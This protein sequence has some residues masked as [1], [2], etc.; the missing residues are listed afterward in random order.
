MYRFDANGQLMMLELE[1]A[2][3]TGAPPKRRPGKPD[4]ELVSIPYFHLDLVSGSVDLFGQRHWELRSPWRKGKRPLNTGAAPR[5]PIRVPLSGILEAT[6]V[7]REAYLQ[8]KKRLRGYSPFKKSITLSFNPILKT[9]WIYQDFFKNWQDNKTVYKDNELSILKTTYKDNKFLTPDDIYS[10]EN[11]SDEY[12]RNV[13]TYGNWGVLGHVIFKNWHVEDLSNLIPQFDHI[14]NGIDFGYSSDPN[15]LIKIHLDKKHKKLY[16]FDEWYQ[17]GMGDDELVRVCKEFFG[18]GIVTCDSAEPKT[19]DYLS[20]N[21]INA[22]PAVKGADSINRGIRYL[23]GYEIIIHES[24]QNF[25]NEI[26]Q[27]HWK[28]DKYGNAMAKPVDANN[29]LLDALRYAIED[30][31]LSAEAMAGVRL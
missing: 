11:E 10:L 4:S 25:K 31:M 17:A 12:F 14:Y 16:V 20:L 22:I 30:E 28:E 13:Y 1:A 2:E 9:H 24:C 5:I 29:H 21:G 19:I 6:E 27:Y 8:L 7:K 23:Q 3:R 15:A 26:E 18:N